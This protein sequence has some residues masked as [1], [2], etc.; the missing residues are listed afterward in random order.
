LCESRSLPGLFSTT[1]GVS[2]KTPCFL[3]NQI[4]KNFLVFSAL[5]G[6]SFGCFVLEDVLSFS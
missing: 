6:A 1:Q 5:R 3:H 4:Q 2:S